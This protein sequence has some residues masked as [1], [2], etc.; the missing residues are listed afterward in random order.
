MSGCGRDDDAGGVDT[1]AAHEALEAHGGVDEFL[2]LRVGVVGL[3]ERRGV[4]ERLLE[5]D[6]DGGGDHF[7]DAVDFAVGHF[8]G[9]ADVLDGGLGGHGVE[10][11]DLGDAV[12]AV[13]AV[14][15]LDDLAAAVHAEVDVDIGHA[16]ALGVEEA[17]E[18]Q[19]VLQRVDV[20]DFHDVGDERTCG[21]ATA[22]ADGMLCSRA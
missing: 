4:A 18:E 20:G 6:A 22:W 11:D 15:V 12:A 14:D 7:G 10:G 19:L 5:R 21:G 9:A 3:F 13:L 8:E 1:C 17:L 2:D 16:D